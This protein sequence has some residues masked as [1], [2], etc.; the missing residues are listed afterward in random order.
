MNYLAHLL[1]ADD[2]DASRIGNL[3]GDFTRG[4]LENL[5]EVYPAELVRG[6]KMHRA[7][8][9]F[10]DD[11][12]TFKRGRS[13]L[14]RDR[15]RFAG[16]I[17][18]IFYDHLLCVHWD[19]FSSIPLKDFTRQVYEALERNPD[20]H[21]GR[22]AKLFPRIKTENWLMIYQTLDG[23][24]YTLKRVSMRSERISEV[25]HS[26]E[27]LKNNYAAFEEL[28][29]E[30]MPELVKFVSDWKRMNV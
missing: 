15:I 9:R 29:H 8:D 13:L 19:K 10:T 28:F 12:P 26:M 20:W 21:A 11:H 30:F 16:I 24:D 18:D 6:I 2:S 5:R 1:L 14:H 17:I 3:L 7:V 22:L 25:A 4:P 23:L 27:D